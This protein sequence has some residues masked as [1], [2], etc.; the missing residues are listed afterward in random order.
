[1]NEHIFIGQPISQTVL[2]TGTDTEERFQSN[3]SDPEKRKMLEQYGWLN[4]PIEYSF[5][6]AGYRSVEFNTSENGFMVLG[7]SFTSGVGLHL[8]QIWPEILS[9]KLNQPVWNLGVGGSGLDTAYR[10]AEHYIPRLKPSKVVLL[11]PEWTRIEI[12]D[13]SEFPRTLNHSFFGNNDPLF[14][15]VF[16]KT[17]MANDAN[18]HYHGIKNIHSIAYICQ[19][20]NID[21][22][23]Y[24]VNNDFMTI[25]SQ[26]GCLGRDLMHNGPDCH[27]VFA[28]IVYTDIT[29]NK[30]YQPD[31]FNSNVDC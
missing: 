31:L 19:R 23:C 2:W 13:H 9:K 11:S 25:Q 6:S 16:M 18:I 10:L 28:D 8:H 1:M 5:N 27:E 4:D 14:T 15:N 3:L 21:F 22:Y 26:T 30:T 29:N 24:D 17:W 12:W 20:F 7:C